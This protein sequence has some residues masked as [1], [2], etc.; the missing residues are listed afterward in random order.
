MSN[1]AI[2]KFFKQ[3]P[4][5]SRVLNKLYL[6]TPALYGIMP[7]DEEKKETVSKIIEWDNDSVQIV[8]C[9]PTDPRAITH[10]A[11]LDYARQFEDD[12]ELF[13]YHPKDTSLDLKW[14]GV[15]LPPP[16]EKFTGERWH[17]MFTVTLHPIEN[18]VRMRIWNEENI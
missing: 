9:L 2:M 1:K 11:F 18:N 12:R 6:L 15:R 14:Y 17:D 7:T 4:Y 5:D 3:D 10:Q 8:A 13:S 16:D